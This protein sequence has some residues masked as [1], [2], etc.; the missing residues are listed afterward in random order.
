[1]RINE[2]IMKMMRDTNTRM[3]IHNTQAAMDLVQR[4]LQSVGLSGVIDDS[5][6][7]ASRQS[8]APNF[9]QDLFAN[10]ATNSPI[11]KMPFT[12][13]ADYPENN[14]EVDVSDGGRFIDAIYTDGQ[15]RHRYKLFIPSGYKGQALPLVVMLH[16]CT[17]NPDDFA[18]GTQ[19]NALAETEQCFVAYPA[20]N[21]TANQSK[22]WNWFKTLHQQR[23]HGE[24]ALIAGITRAVIKNY[25]INE[26]AVYIA[27]L[28]AGGA[29]ALVMATVYPELYAA[30]GVHSGLPYAS[31]KDLPSALAAMKNGYSTGSASNANKRLQAIPVIV[32][33]GKQDHTVHP[34]NG[35]QIIEQSVEDGA[36]QASVEI[37]RVPNGHAYTRSLYYDKSGQVAAEHWLVHDAG[38]AWSGGNSRG[39][40]TDAKGPNA[41]QEM[42][43]FF[44]TR[45][46]NKG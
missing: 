13:P 38:H 14:P 41:S 44:F 19:M 35:E 12:E 46:K 43:R 3:K 42:M 36:Q 22:C 4:T 11:G 37:G 6:N 30:A 5:A 31:A 40:Y 20:Q 24:A 9:V 16:G 45:T 33:H 10:L 21:S 28:S 26:E 29:M 17:Q 34:R 39:T 27:G 18:T 15:S 2:V 23:D 8:Q 1:M 7:S 25:S 32:F